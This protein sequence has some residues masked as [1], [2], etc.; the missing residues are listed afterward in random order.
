MA[1]F[2]VSVV[3]ALVCNSTVKGVVGC[4]EGMQGLRNSALMET[5][6]TPFSTTSLAFEGSSRCTRKAHVFKVTGKLRS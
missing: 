2:I 1:C 6:T 5:P 3:G 4:Y